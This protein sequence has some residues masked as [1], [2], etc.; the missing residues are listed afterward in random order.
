MKKLDSLKNAIQIVPIEKLKPLS[1]DVNV[2]SHPQSEIDM[3]K[4]SIE[5]Y[6][7]YRPV[8]VDKDY[9]VY[10]GNALTEALKQMGAKEVSVVMYSDL[11]D[12]ELKTLMTVDNWTSEMSILKKNKISDLVRD[13]DLTGQGWDFGTVFMDDAELSKILNSG[14]SDFIPLEK[15][16]ASMTEKLGG[17]QDDDGEKLAEGYVKCPNCGMTIKVD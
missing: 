5:I 12:E 9:N 14:G 16:H 17:H 2:A 7:Q 10:A 3:L 13:L 6:G 1:D 15:E 4:K 8:I 11:T